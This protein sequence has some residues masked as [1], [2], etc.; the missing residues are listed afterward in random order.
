MRMSFKRWLAVVLCAAS[1]VVSLDSKLVYAQDAN[2]EEEV[3]SE[4]TGLEATPPDEGKLP[5]SLVFT[6][7][8]NQAMLIWND[9]VDTGSNIVGSSPDGTNI[10][11]E[12]ESE[13]GDGW[14]TGFVFGLDILN[15]QSDTVDQFDATGDG[16]DVELSD[17]FLTLGRENW[18]LLVFGYAGTGSDG[19]DSINAANADALASPDVSDWNANFFVRGN[20]L[21]LDAEIRWGD[22]IDGAMAGD[23]RNVIYYET[24]EFYGLKAAA[25][26]DGVD[27][28]DVGL[29]FDKEWNDQVAVGAAIGYWNNTTGE[30]DSD[31]PVDDS[32]WGGSIAVRHLPTGLN[33][34]FNYSTADHTNRCEEPGEI[35][36]ACRGDDHVYYVIGGIERDFTGLGD[37]SIYGEYYN[38]QKAW[39]ESD[40]EKL[41][42]FELFEDTA[43]ELSDS[44]VTVWGA[45]V[46][47]YIE[48]TSASFYLGYRHYALDVD[49][50]GEDGPVASKALK[51]FDIVMTGV[52]IKF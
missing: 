17:L 1:V 48:N 24:P 33:L 8:L 3:E 47:Q 32:G 44:T 6:M 7:V 27:Y 42:A 18:G 19:V 52:R 26:Y 2:S 31:E 9:G 22:Y 39:N 51:N 41:A 10:T 14:T 50:I 20:D 30:P 23:T 5:I 46:V 36:G 34:A 21:D 11:V 4:V 38:G 40:S 37:T 13:F 43:T 28:W 25:A 15:S 45:G 12:G 49:L 29:H 35:S 16:S